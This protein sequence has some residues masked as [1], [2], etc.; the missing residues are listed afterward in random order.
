[1]QYKRYWITEAGKRLNLCRETLI[2]AERGERVRFIRNNDRP[3]SRRWI[4][5]SDL[6][7]APLIEIRKAAKM[8]G[9]TVRYLNREARRV[10]HRETIPAEYFG[11]RRIRWF[12]LQSLRRFAHG[13]TDRIRARFKPRTFLYKQGGKV[14]R[15]TSRAVV[16]TYHPWRNG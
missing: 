5:E 14:L 2:R 10:E 4:L 16:V 9:V 15:Y 8:M 7:R 13:R 6:I 12:S 1:M 11:R 3:H